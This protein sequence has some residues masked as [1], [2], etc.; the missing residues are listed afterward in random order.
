MHEKEQKIDA[1]LTNENH[2]YFLSSVV[3]LL[4]ISLK[5]SIRLHFSFTSL[6]FP[7]Y[8]LTYFSG[9]LLLSSPFLYL[10]KAPSILYLAL[11]FL[12]M[13]FN[14]EHILVNNGHL[15]FGFWH[16]GSSAVF[17]NSLIH[18]GLL[19]NI[20]YLSTILS[21]SAL[22][23]Y[24]LLHKRSF[25][26][27]KSLIV[28]LALA[29]FI[30]D[31][32]L[33]KDVSV[34][35]WQQSSFL[36]STIKKVL[37]SKVTTKRNKSALLSEGVKFK[38][39]SL[40]IKPDIYIFILESFSQDY[41][42]SGLAS[43]LKNLQ[44]NSLVLNNFIAN[45]QQTNRGL[46]A[47]YCG[48]YPNLINIEAKS[49]I[50][51]TSA[52]KQKRTCLPEALKDLGYTNYFIQSAPLSFMSK[53]QFSR[54]VGFDYALGAEGYITKQV[55]GPWGVDDQTTME[56]V[57]KT[58]QNKASPKLISALTISTHYP[59]KTKK[60][61]GSLMEAIKYTDHMVSL[62]VGRLLDTQKN[63]LVFIT[64]DESRPLNPQMPLIRSNKGLFMALGKGI[65]PQAV[66]TPYSLVDFPLILK[67][68]LEQKINDLKS[69]PNRPIYFGNVYTSRLY[70]YD[71]IQKTLLTCNRRLDCV[72]HKNIK[73]PFR[74]PSGSFLRAKDEE[75]KELK[76]FLKNNEWSFDKKIVSRNDIKLNARKSFNIFRE[77]KLTPKDNFLKLKIKSKEPVKV[78]F[79]TYE[80][81]KP[82]T[83]KVE[84]YSAGPQET[85]LNL[86]FVND[87]TQ[88][89]SLYLKS[90]NSQEVNTLEV[91][92]E[93]KLE[94]KEE[95]ANE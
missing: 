67:K 51:I 52:Q 35:E 5:L 29:L 68:I 12:L 66:N 37:S 33:P 94:D 20:L 11:I 95:K 8:L 62:A 19:I 39:D 44:K 25:T 24:F 72:S 61:E 73:N 32:F 49:D 69:S 42:D 4:L 17:V 28:E 41:L 9:S 83:Q 2:W 21:V 78:T 75:L 53:E 40:R 18:F 16:L 27:K 23:S 1:S 71:P 81:G 88:C 74:G 93:D 36:S 26:F 91:T 43:G 65:S 30:L 3:F 57:L 82:R 45:Q 34:P 86:F 13:I 56:T 60:S 7:L 79:M 92:L 48:D 55:I 76:E 85:N 14:H 6:S 89:L 58:A 80:C 77:F 84:H 22:T 70:S 31:Y 47:L 54:A 64:S 63:A 50:L 90:F 59:Y 46:Y 87:N 15:N 38:K 10:K